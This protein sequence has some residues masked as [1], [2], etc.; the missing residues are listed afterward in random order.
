MWKDFH[1]LMLRTQCLTG[2]TNR[3]FKLSLYTMEFLS[4]SGQNRPE[5]RLLL[6]LVH[7]LM[8]FAVINQNNPKQ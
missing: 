3:F 8:V 2:I 4:A 5:K 7:F 6:F 1:N